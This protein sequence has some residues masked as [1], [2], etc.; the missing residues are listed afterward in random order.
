[1]ADDLPDDAAFVEL[2]F[3]AVVHRMHL[4][5]EQA[6]R[7]VHGEEASASPVVSRSWTR[8]VS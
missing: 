8:P 2:T 1:M 6:R 3:G 7:F 4:T 5:A